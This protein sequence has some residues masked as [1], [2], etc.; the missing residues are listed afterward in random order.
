MDMKAAHRVLHGSDPLA[1]IQI[2]P[3]HLRL[4]V[5]QELRNH[6]IRLRWRLMHSGGDVETLSRIFVDTAWQLRVEL[7]G[8]LHV[9]GHPPKTSLQREVFDAAAE[10]V[11]LP[12]EC[13]QTL[14]AYAQGEPPKGDQRVLAEAVLALMEQAV[15]AADTAEQSTP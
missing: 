1:D 8:L 4:R 7:F 12:A 6:C 13:L 2:D 5:E 14:S 9:L 15:G 11:G 3:E 10:R